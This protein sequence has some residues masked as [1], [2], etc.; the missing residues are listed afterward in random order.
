MSI[1]RSTGCT[2]VKRPI[3]SGRHSGW[4][5]GSVEGWVYWMGCRSWKGKGSFGGEC[6]HPIATK[7]IFWMRG[8]DVKHQRRKSHQSQLSRDNRLSWCPTL[9]FGQEKDPCHCF[10]LSLL[11]SHILDDQQQFLIRFTAKP[12][13]EIEV[14]MTSPKMSVYAREVMQPMGFFG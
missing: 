13:P 5:V 4:S 6:E 3:G 10:Q 7:G 2:V 1:N 12:K 8:G 14:Q 9:K 11:R